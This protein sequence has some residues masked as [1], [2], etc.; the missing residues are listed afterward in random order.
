MVSHQASNPFLR[1]LSDFSMPLVLLVLCAILSVITY[2]E[3]VPEGG[4]AGRRMAKQLIEEHGASVNVF[5]AVGKHQLDVG[6]G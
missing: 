1:F 3:Q 2:G 6:T 5:I 4:A